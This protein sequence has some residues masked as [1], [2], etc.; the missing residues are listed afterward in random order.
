MASNARTTPRAR[1]PGPDFTLLAVGIVLLLIPLAVGI[2]DPDAF[3]RVAWYLRVIAALGGGLAAAAIPGV[4][5]LN[6]P[7]I[8][9]AG[10]IAVFVLLYKFDPPAA[11]KSAIHPEPRFE[12]EWHKDYASIDAPYL[13]CALPA[14]PARTP[15]RVS[16]AGDWRGSSRAGVG[17]CDRVAGWATMVVVRNAATKNELYSEQ[18]EHP[19]VVK[20]DIN[21]EVCLQVTNQSSLAIQDTLRFALEQGTEDDY[22]NRLHLA[23]CPVP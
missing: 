17:P 16:V 4:F 22:A 15:V 9:A 14:I 5:H 20:A 3:D 13:V 6:I 23:S 12:K 10:A 2:F 7:G 18:Y 19:S 8:R 11:V 21:Y 1:Q